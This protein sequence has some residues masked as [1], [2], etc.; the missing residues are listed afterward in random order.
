MRSILAKEKIK[1][2]GLDKGSFLVFLNRKTTAF[3]VLCGNSYLV[4]YNNKNRKIPLD[5][6]QYLPSFFDGSE[7]QF[8]NAIERSLRQKLGIDILEKKPRV[9]LVSGE[10]RV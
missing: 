3:K 10:A 1:W 9:R 8:T 4:Y 5:A 2:D 6:I 7:A